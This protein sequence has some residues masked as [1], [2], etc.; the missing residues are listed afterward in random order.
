[1]LNVTTPVFDHHLDA[2]GIGQ[3]TPALSWTTATD[4]CGRRQRA[5]E[6][7][8]SDGTATGLVESEQSVL[9]PWTGAPLVSRE[10][11]GARVR[12]HGHDGSVSDWSPWSWAE[13]GL[14]NPVQWQAGAA[15]PPRELLGLPDG[16]ALLLRR[17]R[18]GGAGG[19]TDLY[20]DRTALIAQL[21]ITY[22]DGTR[23]TV[24]TD[25]TWR[26]APGPVT[27]ASLYDAE[28]HDARL[29][30][31]GWSE[32]GFDDT[33]WLPADTLTHDAAL[34]VAPTASATRRWTAGPAN[35][36]RPTWSPSSATAMRQCSSRGRSTSAPAIS[37]CCV[38]SIR[39]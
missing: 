36:T 20:G 19:K 23:D 9:V 35:W 29:L 28:K 38:A 11:R 18:L 4:A 30:P 22:A 25:D 7:E 37:A 33:A 32:P 24:V 6:I 13:A 1:L 31:A 26:C 15:A 16:P 21:E 39:A 5:Y 14:L 3:P 17:G 10:R 27:A 8:L 12:V 34:L 2:T